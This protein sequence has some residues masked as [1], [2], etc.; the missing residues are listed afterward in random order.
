MGFILLPIA[1]IITSF[2]SSFT[3]SSILIAE[4]SVIAITCL[5]RTIKVNY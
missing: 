4:D 5:I 2:N 3:T 1:T